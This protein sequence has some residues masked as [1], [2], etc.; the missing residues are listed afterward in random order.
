MIQLYFDLHLHS[1]LSPCAD[2]DMTPANLAGMCAL[3]GLQVVAL[4]DHNSTG[5]CAAFQQAAEKHGLLAIP[6]MELCTRE[7]VHVVCLFPD[8][9]Q[10]NAFSDYIGKLLPN[11][12]NKP[13]VFGNQI[14]MDHEDTVLGEET[15]LLAG[16]ADIS[17]YDVP[18]LVSS[19]KG[20][21][22]PAHIDRQAN[23]LLSQLGV[24]DPELPF[25]LAEVSMRCPENLFA[26][27]DLKNLRYISACDAHYLDQIP[28]AH[29]SMEVAQVTAQGVLDWIS[30]NDLV[31]VN[32]N[33]TI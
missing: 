3:A 16:A 14:L 10:A 28:D 31:K 30:G 23:S 13:K 11:I 8:L 22:Y 9:E 33:S 17:L 18:E 5:N 32:K 12:Q 1:C 19:F 27:R 6:G 26:R 24:W 29:Q 2:D 25:P 7:E 15:R 20:V 21:C 4:T